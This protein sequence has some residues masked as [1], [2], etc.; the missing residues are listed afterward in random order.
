MEIKGEEDKSKPQQKVN[1]HIE[2]VKIT[3]FHLNWQNLRL[4]LGGRR[5][6]LWTL[7][8]KQALVIILAV[9]VQDHKRET[10]FWMI[11]FFLRAI[12]TKLW[13]RQDSSRSNWAMSNR[14]KLL[15]FPTDLQK[16]TEKIQEMKTKV[17][18][19]YTKTRSPKFLPWFLVSNVIYTHTHTNFLTVTIHI[20]H[21]D[22]LNYH[23]Y[24]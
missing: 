13:S 11:C 12:L 20:K 3:Y 7:G 15:C 14:K 19:Y 9:C 17:R 1:G 18:N 21:I 2:L 6:R 10:S 23:K 8:G 16:E 5:G 22:M 4:Y 24:F